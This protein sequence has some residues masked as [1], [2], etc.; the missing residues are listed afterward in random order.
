MGDETVIRRATPEDLAAIARIYNH[1]IENT[2][3]TFHTEPK[4][5]DYWMS[6]LEKQ[7]ERYPLIVAEVDGRVAGW[8]LIRPYGE[9]QAY[10]YTVENAIYVDCDYQGRGLGSALLGELVSAARELGYHAIIALVVG[11]NDV[12]VKLHEKFGFERVGVL[13][14]VGMKFGRWLDLIAMEK[15]L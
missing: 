15:L 9:R 11:E 6:V 7:T 13:R 10:R 14:E 5:L 4:T 2:T 3:A 12:S 8:G 1:A